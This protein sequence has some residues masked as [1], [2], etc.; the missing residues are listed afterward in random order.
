MRN[1]T[2]ITLLIAVPLLLIFGA[3]GYYFY[4][5]SKQKP[6]PSPPATAKE[7]IKLVVEERVISPTLS[8]NGENVWFMAGNGR[9]FR[10]TIEGIGEKEEYL[11]PE[12]IQNP[13]Q[14]IWPQDG[15]DFI[16]EQNLDGHNRYK[17]FH[18]ASQTFVEYKENLT[19]PR[20]LA[21][22]DKIV[23]DWVSGD[24]THKLTVSDSDGTN[25]Q[26][27]ADL[28][29]P[30]YELEASSRKQEIALWTSDRASSTPIFLVDL[31]TAKFEDLGDEAAYQGVKFSPD[32]TKLLTAKLGDKAD[33]TPALFLFDLSTKQGRNLGSDA[34]IDAA[35][36][37][38]DSKK[39]IIASKGKF[40]SYNLETSAQDEIYRF[41]DSENFLPKNLFL[42]PEKP[43][44]FFTDE[45]TGYLYQ[46]DL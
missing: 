37:S 11:L 24:L 38:K 44:L 14:M 43:I 35:V 23:Y 1:K 10:K 21:P 18:S 4:S 39:I 2:F 27:V 7:K 40:I 36:W 33:E 42:H 5:A 22:G 29:R 32:G 3:V 8:F 46:L 34:D 16:V 30:N 20:F 6:P 45:K 12:V 25:Y 9:L 26:K 13:V 15:S 41:K 31:F 17:F 28:I 19:K